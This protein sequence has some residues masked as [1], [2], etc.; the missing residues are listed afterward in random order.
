[1]HILQ[2]GTGVHCKKQCI[3]AVC[4]VCAYKWKSGGIRDANVTLPKPL[5]CR[6]LHPDAASTGNTLPVGVLIS[7]VSHPCC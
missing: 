4:V 7:N 5:L 6:I 3:Q 1:M 2:I